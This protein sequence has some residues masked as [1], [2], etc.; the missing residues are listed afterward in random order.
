MNKNV[1]R[2]LAVLTIF[3]SLCIGHYLRDGDQSGNPADSRYQKR[4]G[5]ES[6]NNEVENAWLRLG[7]IDESGTFPSDGQQVA[8][9][10]RDAYL[11]AQLPTDGFGD[12]G[13]AR[14]IQWVS[15]GPVNVGGRTRSLFIDPNNAKRMWAGAATGGVWETV[16]GGD[17]RTAMNKPL[18]NFAL[19]SMAFDPVPGG[20]R[21]LPT[22]WAGT[23]EVY[24]GD[25][26]Y[27]STDA[28]MTWS[29]ISDTAHSS[30]FWTSVNSISIAHVSSDTYMLASIATGLGPAG[31]S[32][33]SDGGDHWS[34]STFPDSS[35]TDTSYFVSFSP[36]SASSAIGEIQVRPTPSTPN[37]SPTAY[38][39][40]IYSTDGGANWVSATRYMGATPD[41]TPIDF[42]SI[43]AS[44]RIEFAYRPS[45]ASIVYAMDR[46]SGSG[47][48]SKSTDGGHSFS[49]Y[50][51]GGILDV[52][53]YNNTLW[54]SPDDTSLIVAGGRLQWRSTDGG[55]NFNVIG[56]GGF[57]E[58]DPHNDTHRAIADPTY[59]GTTNR[60]VFLGTDGGVFKAD[61][62]QTTWT[63]DYPPGGSPTPT[64][65]WHKLNNTYQ[66]TQFYSASGDA[67]SGLIAGGTQDNGVLRITA[68]NPPAISLSQGD[69][70]MTAV[71]GTTCFGQVNDD[72][73]FFRMPDCGSPTPQGSPVIDGITDYSDT[74]NPVGPSPFVTDPSN[75]NRAYFGSSGVFRSDNILASPTATPHWVAIRPNPTV[76]PSPAGT[77][78]DHELAR[79]PWIRTHRPLF[80]RQNTYPNASWGNS[81]EPR[82]HLTILVKLKSLG[83]EWTITPV[84]DPCH[85][86]TGS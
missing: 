54:L 21:G 1:W 5:P 7:W 37:P 56:A 36:A 43:T 75:S 67:S 8:V 31:I 29:R 82:T 32:R 68:T 10:Q 73:H 39:R 19:G 14:A 86:Q 51:L 20:A 48:L 85:Y 45:N 25:G 58:D 53:S 65:S 55:Q 42:I 11:A 70:G 83:R 28:G 69:G 24:M 44:G 18:N 27:K 23:G 49:R 59:N 81:V 77:R 61:D 78:I 16:N 22:L 40:A 71:V 41:P 35:H 33:S 84:M 6:T 13:E 63:D 34:M 4:S 64:P 9:E 52:N 3:L 66:T 15:R 57:G 38:H 60:R 72:W 26:L 50:Q 12:N 74:N 47:A 2:S 80:G 79:L 46:G 30:D 76:D 62:I 17:T